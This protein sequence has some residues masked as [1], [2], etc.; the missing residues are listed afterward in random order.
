ML[1]HSRTEITSVNNIIR[2]DQWEDWIQYADATYQGWV[3]ESHTIAGDFDRFQPT[4]Y[5]NFVSRVGSD[6]WTP[7]DDDRERYYINWSF[8]PPPATYRL[9]NWNLASVPDYGAIVAAIEVLGNQTL[10]TRVRPYAAAIGT[11]FAENEHDALH[12][13]LPE[14][15]TEHPHSFFFHPVHKDSNDP[16]SDVVAV[17][18][19]GSAWDAALRNL[20]PEG[21]NGITVVVKNNCNQ[22]YTY[23][24][25]L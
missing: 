1:L 22:T 25:F 5:D 15:E 20:L 14:G 11:A 9:I 12:S 3:N 7:D 4:N 24:E 18:S 19:G 10:V 23:S 6:G 21:V 8:S 2:R 16:R 17:V 13:T